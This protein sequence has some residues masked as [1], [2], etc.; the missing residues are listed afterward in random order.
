MRQTIREPHGRRQS[1]LLAPGPPPPTLTG[2]QK[3]HLHS[4]CSRGVT[5]LHRRYPAI[6]LFF[7]KKMWTW[8][9]RLDWRR[10]ATEEDVL[11][12]LEPVVASDSDDEGGYISLLHPTLIS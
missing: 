11:V 3:H 4:D 6:A 7:S 9:A 12:D 5:L 10:Y 8:N 2:R 1:R